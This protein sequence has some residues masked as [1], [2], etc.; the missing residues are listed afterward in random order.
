MNKL[1]FAA[2]A[3]FGIA[4]SAASATTL[5]YTDSVTLQS[6]NWIEMLSVDQFDS[7][8]G[9]LNSVTV[10][11]TGTV[12]GEASAESLDAAPATITLDLSALISASTA[13]LGNVAAVLPVVS[14]TEMLDMFD[15]LIDFD[16]PSGTASGVVTADDMDTGVLTGADMAEF[17]GGGSVVLS[18]EAMGQSSGTGAGNLITS[19]L[20]SAAATV[21]V[22]YDYDPAQGPAPVPLP[23]SVLL[24]GAAL[25]GL[26]LARRKKA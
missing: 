7:A 23:A 12:E 1:S 6:T 4:A 22:V 11:L 8:L 20:T 15:G 14:S 24:L 18:L 19:F 17:I 26:G 10:M 13:N 2:A 3:A 16:G 21:T 9:D 5:S 25:G